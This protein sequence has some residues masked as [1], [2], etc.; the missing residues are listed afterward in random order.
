M[1]SSPPP[2]PTP[3][4][5]HITSQG[6]SIANVD[7]ATINHAAYA[8]VTNASLARLVGKRVDANADLMERVEAQVAG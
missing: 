6:A 4:L 8:A 7:I 2:P 1:C 3:T 5:P